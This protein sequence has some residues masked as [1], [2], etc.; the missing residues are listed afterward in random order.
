MKILLRI[1]FLLNE[2]TIKP[3]NKQVILAPKVNHA[4]K[5]ID[6][7]PYLLFSCAIMFLLFFKTFSQTTNDCQNCF[8]KHVNCQ[9]ISL[10]KLSLKVVG[11]YVNYFAFEGGRFEKNPENY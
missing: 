6:F 8:L 5:F 9:L 3:K 2:Y 1:D 10:S 11:C 4:N 7:Y